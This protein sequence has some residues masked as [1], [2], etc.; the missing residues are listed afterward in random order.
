MPAPLVSVI[1]IFLDEEDFLAE[2][3]ESV[4]KQ[5]HQNWQLLLVDDGSTDASA[6]VAQHY[7]S[8]DARVTYLD[9]PNHENRGMS[10][11]RNLALR[12]A[13]GEYVALLDADDAWYSDTLMRQID[14]LSRHPR[15][16]LAAG[17]ALWWRSWAG[18]G[19]GGD[20]C[21][22]VAARAPVRNQLIEP[23]TFVEALVRDGGAVPCPCTVIIR[24]ERLREVGGFEEAFPD[25]Y[26][27]QAVYAK[28]GLRFPVV[29]TEQCLARYRQHEAQ[30]CV[31]A[32]REGRV[33]QIRRRFLDWL[34]AYA[35]EREV[36][37]DRFW[38]ALRAAR[39][40]FDPALR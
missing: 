2:A 27:D 7:A 6:R 25:L 5:D 19:V 21:D 11:S 12:H 22:V 39:A 4:A 1:T 24:T 20:S 26:E 9:H 31:R 32:E 37:D 29:I 3:I 28:L 10:M 40:P 17:T 33:H 15:A 8:R 30:C 34:A 16:A 13:R 23:P 36:A 35:R 14:L 18:D 38:Y